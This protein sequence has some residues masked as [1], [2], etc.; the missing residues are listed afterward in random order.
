M[1]TAQILY[2]AFGLM[3][4]NKPMTPGVLNCKR[5]QTVN[6]ATNYVTNIYNHKRQEF[7]SRQRQ[8]IFLY[9]TASRPTRVHPASFPMGAGVLSPGGKAAG[10]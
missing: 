6:A 2:S 9:S 8:E 1:E 10:L 5:R 4:G 7:D 3:V